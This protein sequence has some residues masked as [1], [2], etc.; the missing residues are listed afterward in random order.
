MRF[1]LHRLKHDVFSLL[2]KIKSS[3][4]LADEEEFKK[5]ALENF[6]L[7]E[8]VLERIFLVEY[9]KAGRY[10]LREGDYN[11]IQLAGEVF[12]EPL[13]GEAL[14][15]GDPYLFVKAL[16]A[17]KDTIAE[18]KGIRSRKDS[19]IIKGDLDISS[20]IKEFFLAF[21]EYLLFLQGASLRVDYSKIEIVWEGS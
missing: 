14:L 5:I 2:F 6:E 8:R 13:K 7:L 15:R 1:E 20:D 16:G 12:G 19:L 17:L 11:P 4:E 10:T 21:A 18:P 3:V 9:I